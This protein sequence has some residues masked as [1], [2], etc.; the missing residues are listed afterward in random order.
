MIR[1]TVLLILSMVFT[2]GLLHAQPPCAFDKKHDELLK[3]NP[4]FAREVEQNNLL[5]QRLVAERKAKKPGD[6]PQTLAIVTIPVVVHVMHTGGPVGSIYNPDDAQIIGAIN[7]LNRVYAGS[8]PGMTPPVEGG[9]I[10]NMEIQFALAQRTPSCGSTNGI[11]RV[12]ASGLANYTARGIN[13]DSTNGCPELSLKNLARWNTT[14][15]YNIWVVNKIDSKDGT[16]GQFIAGYAF[17][18]GASSSLD[19]T[20]MLATQMQEDEKTLPHEIGHALNLYHTFHPSLNSTQCSANVNCNTQGDQVCDT[21]PNFLNFNSGTGVF[22]FACRTGANPCAGSA[23]YTINTESNFM[24]YT[25][26]YTLFT[27]GQKLRVQ[28]AMTLPSRAGLVD[29]ANLALV[30]CGTTINFSVPTGNLTETASGTTSDCRTYT[31]YTYQMVIGSAPTSAA[32]AT[33]GFGGTAVK[34]LDYEVTTNGNFI[35]PDNV[36]HFAANATAAQSFTVRIYDDGNVE[37]SESIILNFSVNSGGGD[38]IAG[39]TTP[40]LTISLGDN[41]TAPLGSSTGVYPIGSI[42][43]VIDQAPFNAMLDRQ[44]S[45][46]LYK[47]SELT[48][49]GMTPGTITS[50]QLYVDT[51]RSTRPFTNLTIRMANT[52]ANYLRNGTVTAIGGMTTVYTNSAYSTTAGWNVFNLSVPFNWTGNS[53]AFEICF[54]NADEDETNFND[55]I[56][57]FY[58]GGSALQSNIFFENGINCGT[59]FLN[60]FIY[61]YGLK[62]IIRL[63]SSVIGTSIET[64][65]GAATSHHLQNGSN[66]Y[67]YSNNNRLMMSLSNISADL[68]CVNSSLEQAGTTWVTYQ[69]GQRSAKVFAVTPSGNGATTTYTGS[70]YFTT[71][72]LAGKNP[73]L[74]RL[75][76]TSAL[77]IAAAN[78]TNTVI[79]TP[80]VTY[81][82]TDAVGFTADFTGFSK[83]FLVDAA[84]TLPVT[85][86]DLVV[87]LNTQ[88]DG[89]I[90]WSTSSELNNAGFDVETSRDG[91]HFSMLG[92]VASLGNGTTTNHYNFIHNKPAPGLHFYRLKQVDIDGKKTYSKIISLLVETDVSKARIYPVPATTN[93]TI[94]FGDLL[95][96]TDLEIFSAEMKLIKREVIGGPVLTKEINVEHLPAGIYF[97]RIDRKGRTE[98]LRFFKK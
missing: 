59:S 93:I 26:C 39:T 58:D 25:N 52:S 44:R 38:A 78:H 27:N 18:P 64:V 36:V 42:A 2:I 50:L 90:H 35:S 40:T 9:G 61:Q 19:G 48:A 12:N 16:S 51:K 28:A 43:T 97:V 13:A 34:G 37:S 31:D 86:T 85:L 57:A 72:E 69:G 94:H 1:S 41:D 5:I 88:N 24:S 77:N 49:A 32:T 96:N 56:G 21:D 30:P 84:V 91:L 68:G 83:F 33:L 81:L 75:A 11:N 98:V 8:W 22:S 73:A 66:D 6:Q 63:G 54:T 29:P 53:L 71:A 15:Y 10:V 46:Y 47:A 7:Y 74:L 4:V 92:N 45:Q 23:P 79:V 95:S 82:G 67:L 89:E 55:D 60:V 14:D 70:F 80:T 87:K 65:A 17:S 76:K 62:P 20:V 3:T